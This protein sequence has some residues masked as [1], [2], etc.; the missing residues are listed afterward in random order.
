MSEYG[1]RSNVM[2][3]DAALTSVE[4][5][6]IGIQL[7]SQLFKFLRN[8]LHLVALTPQG[9]THLVNARPQLPGLLI[10]L[11]LNTRR[12]VESVLHLLCAAL[13]LLQLL[14]HHLHLIV[15]VDSKTPA[16]AA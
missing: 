5:R 14:V 9:C 6:E 7:G 10:Q 1:A 8:L 15:H 11:S 3:K 4:G 2:G 16:K 13:L 12:L